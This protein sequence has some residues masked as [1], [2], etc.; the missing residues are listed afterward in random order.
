[1]LRLAIATLALTA[2]I[3]AAVQDKLAK[4]VISSGA[5]AE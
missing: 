3:A 4:V 5:K 1:M 2:G